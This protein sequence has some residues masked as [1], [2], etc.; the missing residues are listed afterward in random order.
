MM[1]IVCLFRDVVVALVIQWDHILWRVSEMKNVRQETQYM[2][3]ERDE[4]LSET[5]NQ[6][7]KN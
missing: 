7:M 3:S 2:E 5:V 6:S 4:K 1:S